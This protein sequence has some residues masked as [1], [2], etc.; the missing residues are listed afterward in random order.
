M[1]QLRSFRGLAAPAM[2]ILETWVRYLPPSYSGAVSASKIWEST[3]GQC[4]GFHRLLVLS[5]LCLQLKFGINQLG[6]GRK[7]K[8]IP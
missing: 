1:G 7:G 8:N 4:L 5:G 3:E 6:K 2:D